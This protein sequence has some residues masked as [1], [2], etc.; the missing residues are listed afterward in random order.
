MMMLLHLNVVILHIRT[1]IVNS[2]ISKHLPNKQTIRTVYLL[3]IS[4][5]IINVCT[6]LIY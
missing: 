5:Y 3:F 4:K 6:N 1:C 2:N